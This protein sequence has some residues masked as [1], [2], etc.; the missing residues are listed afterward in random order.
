MPSIRTVATMAVVAAV[1][2]IGI[3]RYQSAKGR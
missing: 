3:E 1:V 2:Y